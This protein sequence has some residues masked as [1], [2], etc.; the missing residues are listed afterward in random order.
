M[1]LVSP[2]M[3]PSSVEDSPIQLSLLLSVMMLVAAVRIS[4]GWLALRMG[5][6]TSRWRG[7][8]TGHVLATV[9]LVVV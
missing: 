3:M 2:E 1:L 4:R 7:P 5:V 8:D 9:V 6:D